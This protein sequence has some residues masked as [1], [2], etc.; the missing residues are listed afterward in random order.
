MEKVLVRMSDGEFSSN[1]FYNYPKKK[2]N[3]NS[4][5]TNLREK[6]HGEDETVE[7]QYYCNE[8]VNNAEEEEVEQEQP[9]EE[10]QQHQESGQSGE[11]EQPIEEEQHQGTARNSGLGDRPGFVYWNVS[12]PEVLDCSIC[13]EPLTIPVY[14]VSCF[15]PKFF[16]N[17]NVYLTQLF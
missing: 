16:S 2:G 10:E 7:R 1:V 5:Q 15:L 3:T 9:I 11:H 12:D 4:L 13:C 6:T 17:L 8:E 14:Q